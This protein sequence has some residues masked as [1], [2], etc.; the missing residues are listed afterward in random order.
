MFDDWPL[1]LICCLLAVVAAFGPFIWKKPSHHLMLH[2][3]PTQRTRLKTVSSLISDITACAVP[4]VSEADSFSADMCAITSE[5]NWSTI[6][7][8]ASRVVMALQWAVRSA[9][10]REAHE[11]TMTGD[12]G[13]EFSLVNILL[14]LLVQLLAGESVTCIV[15]YKRD[16]NDRA[17][18]ARHGH[19]NVY[20]TDTALM[21]STPMQDR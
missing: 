16:L 2:E 19:H 13:A 6:I 10:H 21:K 7:T 3:P 1:C 20:T 14:R 4:P 8:I 15:H 11:T 17:H 9:T 12:D 18:V 5:S